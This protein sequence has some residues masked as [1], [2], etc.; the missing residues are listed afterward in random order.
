MFLYS[1]RDS[2]A[3]WLCFYNFGSQEVIF[4]LSWVVHFLFFSSKGQK[5]TADNGFIH[6]WSVSLSVG[7][8][9]TQSNPELIRKQGQSS[10]WSSHHL[11]ACPDYWA[12]LSF[13][14]WI[15]PTWGLHDSYKHW[16]SN[17]AFFFFFFFFYSQSSWTTKDCIHLVISNV[18]AVVWRFAPTS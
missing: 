6:R 2:S 18:Q 8:D 12:V 14:P 1:L 9:Y 7:Q 3:C 15:N 5:E 16:I 17:K 10:L 11:C 13:T 4:K